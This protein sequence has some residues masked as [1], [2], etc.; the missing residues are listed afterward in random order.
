MDRTVV[1]GLEKAVLFLDDLSVE[2]TDQAI[3]SPSK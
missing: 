1:D 2:D 3:I